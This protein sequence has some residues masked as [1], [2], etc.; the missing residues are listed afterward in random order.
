MCHA[1]SFLGQ[2]RLCPPVQLAQKYKWKNST[3]KAGTNL[4]ASWIFVP[5]RSA[6]ITHVLVHRGGFGVEGHH[7]KLLLAVLVAANC[8]CHHWPGRMRNSF[9][10]MS[11]C[12]YFTD[13]VAPKEGLTFAHNAL[14]WS[15][16]FGS[17]SQP[18]L[19]A[20]E[21]HSWILRSLAV[22]IFGIGFLKCFIFLK[23]RLSIPNHGRVKAAFRS[24]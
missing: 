10:K 20:V 2:L 6:F 19:W 11:L 22:V 21:P 4:K 23:G 5:L 17:L 13:R 12:R 14:F 9:G 3:I 7:A 16:N 8:F 1:R 18:W 15:N 24:S